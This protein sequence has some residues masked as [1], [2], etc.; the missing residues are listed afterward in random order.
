ML[1]SIT[2]PV[3]V[4]IL[5]MDKL[6]PDN[7]V[8]AL[9][10]HR[11]LAD[12]VC[13]QLKHDIIVGKLPQ[14]SKILEEDLAKVYGSS[15]GPLREAIRRLEGMRLVVRTPNAGA[16]V[17]TLTETMMAEVYVVRE[18]LEGMSARLAA[19]QMFTDEIEALWDLLDQHEHGI[20]DTNGKVYFQREGDLDFHYRI[21]LGSK[22]RWL[23][24]LL[25]SELYQLIRMC[26]HCSSR[27][28]SRPTAAL[29][30]HRQIVDAIAKRDAE[31]AELLMRRHISNAWN[32]VKDLLPGQAHD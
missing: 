2:L 30:E 25:S 8:V 23:I 20:D 12:R 1:I 13:S 31:L 3:F 4:Y 28:P 14:G 32:I 26:R 18:A 29:N 19:Q 10:S 24:Q 27:L 16:R 22:N 17:V 21:A 9:D 5:S 6:P 11:T 15:R 7:P